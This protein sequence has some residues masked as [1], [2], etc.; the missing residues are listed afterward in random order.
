MVEINENSH[1]LNLF[2]D[3]SEVISYLSKDTKSN[4]ETKSEQNDFNFAKTHNYDEAKN[5]FMFGDEALYN[6]L[7]SSKIGAEIDRLIGSAINKT[8]Y[9]NRFYG[10]IPNVPAFLIGNPINMINN[11]RNK[12]DNK[13]INIFLNITCSCYVS[14]YDIEN[15][16]IKYLKLIDFLEKKGYRCNLYAG[17]VAE[18]A[19]HGEEIKHFFLTKIKT[20]R[21]PLN[22]KKM[23]FP[24]AHPSMLRRMFFK[25]CEVNDVNEDKEITHDGY[26]RPFSDNDYIKQILKKDIGKDF[27]IFSYQNYDDSFDDIIN[28]LE[29]Q[30]IKIKGDD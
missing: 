23:A 4:R 6:R 16:G 3:I 29:K 30:G 19:T 10:C 18:G 17:N 22:I 5:L 15:M 27:V 28:K 14:S 2:D 12:I 11:E 21:E 20:D 25:W 8:K 24:I 7:K 1:Y 13:I 9:E 26:G